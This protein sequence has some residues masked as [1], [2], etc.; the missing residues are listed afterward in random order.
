[1]TEV[2]PD[3]LQDEKG[4]AYF[5]VRLEAEGNGFGENKPIL[6]GMQAD[7]DILYGRQLIISSLIRPIQRLQTAALR[8]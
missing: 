6:P 1:M 8:Q 3:T 4:Q 5:R 7:V 2:S